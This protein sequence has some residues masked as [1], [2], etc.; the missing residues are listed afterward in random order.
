MSNGF[1]FFPSFFQSKAN[2]DSSG[3][4]MELP[5]WMEALWRLLLLGFGAF[6]GF[7]LAVLSVLI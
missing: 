2:T 3:T 7:A 5:L 6:C 4:Q 1:S